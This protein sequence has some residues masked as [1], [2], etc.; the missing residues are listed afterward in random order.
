MAIACALAMV[1][2]AGAEPLSGRL[3]GRPF[4]PLKVVLVDGGDHQ[5]LQFSTEVGAPCDRA[6]EEYVELSS[7]TTTRV[8]PLFAAGKPVTLE[9]HNLVVMHT[10]AP[11]GERTRDLKLVL[12]L[13]TIDAA[14]RKARGRI[15]WAADD[16]SAL[17]GAFE[18]TYCA[19]KS[20]SRSAAAPANGAEWS[21]SPPSATIPHAAATGNLG[22][23]AFHA[24]HVNLIAY[25]SMARDDAWFHEELNFFA[26]KPAQPCIDAARAQSD[27]FTVIFKSAKV[28]AGPVEPSGRTIVRWRE[29]ATS[30]MTVDDHNGSKVTLLFDAV[31]RARKSVRGRIYLAVDDAGKSLLVGGFNATYCAE[32]GP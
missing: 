11:I 10:G 7:L 15:D 12:T 18:A 30:Y 14:A 31:D 6:M 24:A 8:V 16:D 19:T 28:K 22:G 2:L 5:I 23:N 1:R 9:T 4:S 20:Q 32:P 13:E 3:H 17:H 27:G 29:P 26:E 21:L 25:D